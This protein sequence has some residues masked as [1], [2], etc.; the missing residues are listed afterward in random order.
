MKSSKSSASTST[1]SPQMKPSTSLDS[2]R[3]TKSEIDSLRQ[4]KKLISDYVQKELRGSL[5]LKIAELKKG[6]LSG[7]WARLWRHRVCGRYCAHN[8]AYLSKASTLCCAWLAW[9]SMAV[10]ACAMI[11]DLARLVDSLA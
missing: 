6:R 1:P 7:G 8:G 5:G 4:N 10:A 3:L 9:A 2:A 11:C